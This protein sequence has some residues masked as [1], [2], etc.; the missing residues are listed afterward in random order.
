VKVAGQGSNEGSCSVRCRFILLSVVLALCLVPVRAA[1]PER[2]DALTVATFNIRYGTARDGDNAWER[3]R[4]LCIGVIRTLDADVL[5]LQEALAFQLDE[6]RAQLP[7]YAL[8][9]IG[10]DDGR[11]GGEHAAI[12][13][14]SA[15]FAVDRSATVWLSDTP[16]VPGSR[17][18]GNAIT[19]VCTWV[20][21]IDL[22]TSSAIWVY[23][24]HLDHQSQ[25]SRRR[26]VE[27]IAEL[28]AQRPFAD[29]PVIVMGDFNAGEDNAVCR[30]LRG[31][32]A[33]G[34]GEVPPVGLVDSYRAIHPEVTQVGTFNGFA[35]R[36]DGEKIDHILCS[37]GIEIIAAD[38]DRTRGDGGRCPSDHDAVWAQVRIGREDR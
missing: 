4:T 25:E 37:T 27:Y 32:I 22:K 38:I 13:V 9:G 28:I 16:N 6:I 1:G 23:N 17:S 11:R 29:E 35:D 33:S 3:R 15:R 20:R 31:E 8:V 36:R 24:V 14:R 10:R 2:D 26:S 7:G 12:L 5:G 18:W 34:G 19:R 30:F 21:L